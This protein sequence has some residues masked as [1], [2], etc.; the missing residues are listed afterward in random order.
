MRDKRFFDNSMVAMRVLE[1]DDKLLG[2]PFLNSE[3]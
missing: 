1:R 2:I 3:A